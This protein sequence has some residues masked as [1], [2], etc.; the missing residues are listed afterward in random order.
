MLARVRIRLRVRSVCRQARSVGVHTL[1]GWCAWFSRPARRQSRAHRHLYSPTCTSTHE[2]MH[3]THTH[4]HTYIHTHTHTHTHTPQTHAHAYTHVF[5]LPLRAEFD[6]G[7]TKQLKRG[8]MRPKGARHYANGHTIDT[9]PLISPEKFA[10]TSG[11]SAPESEDE[12]DNAS[13][14]GCVCSYVRV[15]WCVRVCVCVL[16]CLSV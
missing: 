4:T 2:D 5:T 11:V 15:C 6:D 3:R 1:C 8:Q 16:R 10:V 7:D 9:L 14:A 12:D 13:T